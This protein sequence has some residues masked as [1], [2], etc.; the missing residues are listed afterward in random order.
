MTDLGSAGFPKMSSFWHM[1]RMMDRIMDEY[2]REMHRTSNQ[3]IAPYWRDADHS[4]LQ[5]ANEAHQV[6]DDDKKFAISLDVSQFKPE[7][8]KVNLD[9]RMLTVEG[10]QECKNENS[11]MARSFIRSWS[12]PEDVN[13]EGLR[14]ELS[15]KGRLTIEA[16]KNPN[17]SKKNIPIQHGSSCSQSEST[18]SRSHRRSHSRKDH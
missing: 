9:G 17:T 1:S 6:V 18:H 15:D 3:P 4:V 16:P 2:L 11:F 13:L 14:T 12:L 8:L 7:E 10:K 5:V